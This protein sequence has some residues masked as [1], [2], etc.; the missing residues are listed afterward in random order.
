M[1]SRTEEPYTGAARRRF[2]HAAEVAGRN[3]IRDAVDT[4]ART[5][6][7]R[8]AEVAGRNSIRDASMAKRFASE[9]AGR[10]CSGAIRIHGGYGYVSDFPV[11]KHDRDARVLRICAFA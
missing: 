10:V 8:S 2:A 7:P 1:S 4:S 11:E 3:S 9:M 6:A 5:M